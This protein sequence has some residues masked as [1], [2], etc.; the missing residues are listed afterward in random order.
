MN[1]DN[2]PEL[3]APNGYFILLGVMG[4]LAAGMIGIFKAKRWF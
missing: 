1:F 3:H 4:A 2:I